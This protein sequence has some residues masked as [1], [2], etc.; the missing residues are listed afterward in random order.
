MDKDEKPKTKHSLLL[1][2]LS[3]FAFFTVITVGFSG[4]NTYI[5]QMRLYKNQCLESLCNIVDYLEGLIKDS[6]EELN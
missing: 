3:I 6:G 1:K 2:I 5:T 4:L